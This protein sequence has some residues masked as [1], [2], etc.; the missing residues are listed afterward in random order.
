MTHDLIIRG[1]DVLDG[2][3]ADSVRA[4]VAIDGDRITAVGDL[5]TADAR[6][7]IDA[8][9][10]LVTPGFV[11]LHTHFDA[12]VGWDPQLRPS[13]WHG[14]TTVLMGN[15][16]VTFAPV[17][18]DG[19]G[20]LA[21]IM[22]SVEDIPAAAIRDGLPW[23]WH[24]YGDYLD[25]VVELQP[26]LNMAGLVGHSAVRYYAMGDAAC[27]EDAHPDTEQLAL[28]ADMV[29]QAVAA[30]AVGFSTS[31][32]LG[33]K[34]PDGRCVPGTYAHIGEYEAILGSVMQAGGGMF[35]AIFEPAN[36][37]QEMQ[38]ARCAADLGCQ[39][40]FSGGAN[41]RQQSDNWRKTFASIEADGGRIASVAQVRA[42]GGLMGL[43]AV[44]PVGGKEWMR[45]TREVRSPQD[46]AAELAKP[47]VVA[48]LLAEG[49]EKGLWFD[50]ARIFP[51]GTDEVP[52]Y[53]SDVRGKS[54]AQLAQEAGVSPV[55]LV[56]QRLCA[57]EGRELFN[58]HMSSHYEDGN[59]SYLELP[60]VIPGINDAG[61][62]A[63]QISDGD[64]F[65]WWL[66]ERVR[67]ESIT[68]LPE[69]IRKITS[70][71]ASVLGLIDRGTLAP[72][73]FADINVIDYQRLQTGY[74]TMVYDFPHEAP[75][76]ITRAKGY[77]ATL[78][79]GVPILLD[80]ELTGARPG[81][82]QRKFNR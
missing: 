23:T 72:G 35:Q 2:T 69:A 36:M 74:P 49:E 37:K 77:V 5:G 50:P 71:P 67:E 55:E 3:G 45:L 58:V 64:S 28:M 26:S 21:Q 38:L 80:D 29:G 42:S 32:L 25:A 68:P 81:Q 76:L 59:D 19:R 14:V 56:V 65:T 39:V 17:K 13:S 22:E 75:H 16:G 79:N 27:D 57:S 30:G 31:R 34:V 15:C 20:Y 24:S 7:V 11:D 8:A 63:S 66:S 9:G 73:Q 33:H 52:Q 78:V 48:R 47:E 1:G 4:D 41:K 46:K 43:A 44:T 53:S 6:Q 18:P 70:L 54:V 10:K 61:A 51:L 62:H 40:L 60:Q 82:V 12:Q